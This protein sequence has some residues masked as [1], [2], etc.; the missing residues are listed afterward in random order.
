[1][2]SAMMAAFEYRGVDPVV[3][4][5]FL[6]LQYKQDRIR[7]ILSVEST[8]VPYPVDDR[9]KHWRSSKQTGEATYFIEDIPLD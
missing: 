6:E 1:M 4:G 9:R 2:Q 5:L 7:E 8:Q 3:Q